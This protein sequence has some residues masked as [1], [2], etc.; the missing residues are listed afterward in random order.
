[1]EKA[2]SGFFRFFIFIFFELTFMENQNQ[3]QFQP[4]D[5]GR[6]SLPPENMRTKKK[7]WVI[8]IA[9]FALILL[10]GGYFAWTKY[11][12]PEAQRE[13]KLQENIDKYTSAMKTFEE[14][15]RA[16]TYGGKTPE[17]TLAMFIDALKKGDIEL[18]SKYFILDTNTK[19]PDYL[20]RR[21]WEGGLNEISKNGGT[22]N[23]ISKLGN[24]PI[25][26]QDDKLGTAIFKSVNSES[27]A[28]VLVDLTFNKYS[29]VWKIESM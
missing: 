18:A 27:I 13:R 1:M 12:S 25:K 4:Q 5:S 21:K 22:L 11:F 8:L 17:E 20:T 23:I 3:A 16:D 29:Q 28:D 24:L 14:T 7:V 19:S 2:K 6:I 10:A 15:M 26:A 9:V